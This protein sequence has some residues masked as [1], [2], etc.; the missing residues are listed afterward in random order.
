MQILGSLHVHTLYHYCEM[1]ALL[2]QAT[3]SQSIW[4]WLGEL[5]VKDFESGLFGVEY[6]VKLSSLFLSTLIGFQKLFFSC[7]SVR[8]I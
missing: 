8:V 6:I 7:R 4:R 1:V 5:Q 3:R 2:L